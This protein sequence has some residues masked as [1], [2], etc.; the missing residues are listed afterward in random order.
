MVQR[1]A[2]NRLNG[3]HSGTEKSQMEHQMAANGPNGSQG[4]TKEGP[5]PQNIDFGKTVGPV[6]GASMAPFWCQNR[7]NCNPKR[8]LN[9]D[10]KQ[11]RIS[12][13]KG[14]KNYA[15]MRRKVNDFLYW[16]NLCFLY[17]SSF[18]YSKMV[19]EGTELQKVMET[20]RK[21]MQKRA[22]KK[23]CQKDRKHAVNGAKTMT[24]IEKNTS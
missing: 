6:L 13:H 10:V 24:K 11:S 20:I 14:S 21:Y 7:K 2:P 17:K 18:Y 23:W 22:P 12:M 4:I 16:P 5:I 3:N 9:V 19:W 15:I 1:M 8:Q